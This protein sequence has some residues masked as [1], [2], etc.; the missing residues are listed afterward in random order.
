MSGS[1]TAVIPGVHAQIALQLLRVLR[2]WVLYEHLQLGHHE[3][4][5][6]VVDGEAV[7]CQ[8]GEELV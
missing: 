4:A 1:R 2:V 8:H 3:G 6:A 7:G 5:L